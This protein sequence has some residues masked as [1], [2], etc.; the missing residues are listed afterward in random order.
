MFSKGY[1]NAGM[2]AGHVQVLFTQVATAYMRAPYTLVRAACDGHGPANRPELAF[3]GKD[4]WCES[5]VDA[6]ADLGTC[7]PIPSASAGCHCSDLGTCDYGGRC[8]KATI[9]LSKLKG[10]LDED[11]IPVIKDTRCDKCANCPTCKLSSRAKTQSLQEAFEQEVIENSVAVDLDD[12][13]V[14][15]ELPFIKR[16]VEFLTKRHSG[17]D[18]LYQARTIY[19]SQCKKPEEV[20]VQIRATHQEL[21]DKGFMVPLS[22]LPEDSQQLVRDASPRHF[23]PW[24]DVYKPGSVSTP[25]RLEV[26]PSCTGSNVIVAKGGNMLQL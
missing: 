6:L 7:S 15:V 23:Y 11:D 2:S 13:K 10:L 21:V 16:P 8:Y 9:P 14:R 19:R 4:Q 3:L 20:K 17:S 5:A 18:N 24:R 26:D 12:R 22:S 25:C 1:A